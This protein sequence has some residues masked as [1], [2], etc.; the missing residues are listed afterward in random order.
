[1]VGMRNFHSEASFYTLEDAELRSV[2]DN[3]NIKPQI[4][5]V[6][7]VLQEG[8]LLGMPMHLRMAFGR[9]GGPKGERLARAAFA[10]LTKFSQ[11]SKS[12]MIL[13]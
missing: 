11:N 6:L 5:L 7:K 8:L 1:M 10:V 13:S 3:E 2:I 9:L 4:E 12:F